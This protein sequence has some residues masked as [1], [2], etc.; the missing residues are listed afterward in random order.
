MLPANENHKIRDQTSPVCQVY[1]R[2]KEGRGWGIG[3]A[4]DIS[5]N[6][7]LLNSLTAKIHSVR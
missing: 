4:C 7:T 2:G 6:A 3:A 1:R 5:G